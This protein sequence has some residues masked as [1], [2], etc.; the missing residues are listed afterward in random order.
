MVDTKSAAATAGL[1][2][3]VIILIVA[4]MI[5]S[6]KLGSH[7]KIKSVGVEIYKDSGLT[8]NATDIDWGILAPGE[9]ATATIYIYNSGNSPE[10][11]SFVVGNWTPPE[12]ANYIT[13]TW[14][15][16]GNFTLQGHEFRETVL[17]LSVSQQI[18]DIDEF[19]NDITITGTGL[20]GE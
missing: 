3:A 5:V 19:N 8:E 6:V 4:L 18:K 10:N 17:T 7:G 15:Y 11:V 13:V 20:K 2:V 12:A 16:A 14:D 1:V 9:A